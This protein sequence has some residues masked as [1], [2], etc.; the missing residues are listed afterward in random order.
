[1]FDMMENFKFDFIEK[2]FY[3]DWVYGLSSISTTLTN[4]L[5]EFFQCIKE[6]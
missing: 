4:F 2:E 5:R 6:Y 3:A 1:M